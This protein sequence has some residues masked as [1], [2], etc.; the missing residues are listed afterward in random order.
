[1]HDCN[2]EDLGSSVTQAPCERPSYGSWLLS[3]SASAGPCHRRKLLLRTLWEGTLPCHNC[4]QKQ[5]PA[6]AAPVRGRLSHGGVCIGGPAIV[7][8]KDTH[9]FCSSQPM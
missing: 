3:M 8:Y 7:S 1:M 2:S 4:S 5:L 9:G 6:R